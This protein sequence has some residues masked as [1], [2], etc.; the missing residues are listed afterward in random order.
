M[1]P[2]GE[3]SGSF[4]QTFP[5]LE[6]TLLPLVISAKVHAFQKSLSEVEMQVVR[7]VCLTV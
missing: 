2:G 5:L 7:G 4:A 3:D 1:W 6:H